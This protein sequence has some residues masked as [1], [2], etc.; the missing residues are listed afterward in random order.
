MRGFACRLTALF[1]MAGLGLAPAGPCLGW[2]A[3][4]EERMA[5][6]ADEA[7]CPMHASDRRETGATRVITQADA[8]RCCAASDPDETAP[9][10]PTSVPAPSPVILPSPLLARAEPA[11]GRH[12]LWRTDIPRVPSDVPR[13]LLLSVLLV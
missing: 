1:L 10:S 13:H 2:T 8:D 12:A 3:A 6:C 4:P 7:R 11:S 9:A 5:C